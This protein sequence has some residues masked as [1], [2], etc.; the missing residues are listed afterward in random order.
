[1]PSRPRS[2]KSQLNI[3][4]YQGTFEEAEARGEGLAR[5]S[6]SSS[7]RPRSRNCPQTADPANGGKT[8]IVK[9]GHKGRYVGVLGAF[10][11]NGGGF[12]FHYQLV[13]LDEFYVTPG[14]E[15]TA[16]KNVVL[17]LLEKYSKTVRD[18]K[19]RMATRSSRTC[20]ASRTRRRSPSRW[21]T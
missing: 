11:K 9:V 6:R 17:P 18:A 19:T 2:K 16:K 7:V 8:L 3:L 14:A 12:D 15:V 5:S 4:L 20:R 1:M 13:P 10:K 21:P